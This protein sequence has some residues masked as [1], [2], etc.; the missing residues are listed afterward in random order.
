MSS[1][2]G[3]MQP[4]MDRI[5]QAGQMGGKVIDTL[6]HPGVALQNLLTPAPPPNHQQAMQQMNQQ[7]NSH[8]NDAANQ[9]FVHPTSGVLQQAAKRV[10]PR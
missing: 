10:Q 3:P 8:N 4:F 7:L 6:S 2:F 9:S 5:H 1:N